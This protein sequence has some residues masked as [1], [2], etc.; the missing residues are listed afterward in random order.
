MSLFL[1]T[2][3]QAIG[4]RF[5]KARWLAEVRAMIC[6]MLRAFT[7]GLCEQYTRNVY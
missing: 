5:T 7:S 4:G 6:E 1:E 3:V 2:E